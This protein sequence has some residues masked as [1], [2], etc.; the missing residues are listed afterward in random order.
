MTLPSLS[1]LRA[2]LKSG[3]GLEGI[4]VVVKE[5]L[6]LGQLNEWFPDVVPMKGNLGMP[7]FRKQLRRCH[8]PVCHGGLCRGVRLSNGGLRATQIQTLYSFCYVLVLGAVL[9]DNGPSCGGVSF[10]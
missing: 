8:F 4:L 10:S 9:V 1:L 5:S 6:L 3:L 2:I 7:L